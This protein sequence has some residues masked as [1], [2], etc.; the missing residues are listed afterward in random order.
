MC[1]LNSIEG[2]TGADERG[3]GGHLDKL[4]IFQGDAEWAS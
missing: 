3:W 1:L 2:G 4:S